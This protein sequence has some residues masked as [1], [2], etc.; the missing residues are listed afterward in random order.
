MVAYPVLSIISCQLHTMQSGLGKRDVN[1]RIASLRVFSAM[2]VKACP[3][4]KLARETHHTKGSTISRWWNPCC[5]RKV[6]EYE[7]IHK[8]ASSISLWFLLQFLPWPFCKAVW[9]ESVK[10]INPFLQKLFV[11]SVLSQTHKSYQN[12]ICAHHSIHESER[13]INTHG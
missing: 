7:S 5:K 10:Q 12:S 4:W 1:R 2:Y 9:W 3:D 13:K 11:V 8:L 6:T